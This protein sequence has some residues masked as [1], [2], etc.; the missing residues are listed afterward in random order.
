MKE[1]YK[2]TR[3]AIA[4]LHGRLDLFYEVKERLNE[5]DILFVLGDCGDRGPE[6]WRTIQTVLDDPQCVY[7]MGNHEDMLIEAIKGWYE[8]RGN[9]IDFLSHDYCY[10]LL[11]SNGGRETFLGWLDCENRDEYFRRLTRLPRYIYIRNETGCNICLTHAGFTPPR[12]PIDRQVLLW[13]RYHL[14]DAWV[15]GENEYIVHGH[16]PVLSVTDIDNTLRDGAM[17]YAGGHKI[18]IDAGAVFTDCV[19]LLNLETL[20]PTLIEG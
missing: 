9:L 6:P 14:Y 10:D 2:M 11:R 18:D 17:F 15:G 1:R 13:D 12:R 8:R 3:Y 5:S 7:L 4:D 16:T 19:C 20:E